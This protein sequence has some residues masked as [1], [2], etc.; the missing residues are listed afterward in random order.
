MEKEGMWKQQ[1]D[2]GKSEA[3]VELGDARERRW[4][5]REEGE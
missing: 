2:G 5:G 1:S 4:R 3:R